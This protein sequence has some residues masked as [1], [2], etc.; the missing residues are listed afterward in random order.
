[1]GLIITKYILTLSLSKMDKCHLLK[2]NGETIRS[3]HL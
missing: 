3:R 2:Q 1:M